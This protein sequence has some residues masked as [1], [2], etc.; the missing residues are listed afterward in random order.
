M[1]VYNGAESLEET[2]ES[3]LGQERAV[4]EFIVVNDGSTDSSPAILRE[5]ARRDPRV[6]VIDQENRGLTRALIKGCAAAKGRYIAR[7]DAGDISLPNRL[8]RQ[9]AILE[10][11]PEVVMVS[12]GTR[13]IGPKGEPLFDVVQNDQELINGLNNLSGRE[14]KGPSSHPSVVF[15]RKDYEAA[16]GYRASF[17]V[18]QDM[19]LWIRLVERGKPSAMPEVMYITQY[20]LG[21]I[22]STQRRVQLESMKQILECARLRRGGQSEE[23]AL[24][25]ASQIGAVPI[26]PVRGRVVNSEFFYFIASCLRHS[27]PEQAR[28][29]YGKAIERNPFN[30]KAL[31]RF[32]L[33][34]ASR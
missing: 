7:Q 6:R 33:L 13:F 19:D 14:I 16:G 31:L 34:A 5:A 12:C 24:I 29:Y 2:L 26:G 3:I 11:H 8:A 15:R 23:P 25:K 32:I 10:D 28:Y 4:L 30:V 20:T 22:S 1:S 27:R 21:G 9:V 17:R 18:A